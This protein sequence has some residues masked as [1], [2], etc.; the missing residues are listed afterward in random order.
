MTRGGHETDLIEAVGALAGGDQAVRPLALFVLRNFGAKPAAWNVEWRKLTKT[1]ETHS[2]LFCKIRDAAASLRY[3]HRSSRGALSRSI[4][5][6]KTLL[7]D[8]CDL[9]A[10]S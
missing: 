10:P 4:F 1:T 8:T 9:R 2:A 7:V 6:A 3:S 5:A